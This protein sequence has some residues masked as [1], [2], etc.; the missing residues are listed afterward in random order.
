ML[1]SKIWFRNFQVRSFHTYPVIPF[2]D[3]AID[4]RE[5][6]SATERTTADVPGGDWPPVRA[7]TDTDI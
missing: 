2:F 7:D 4:N 1:D 6:S 3:G 5:G